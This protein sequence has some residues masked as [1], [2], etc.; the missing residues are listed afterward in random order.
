MLRTPWYIANDDLHRDLNIQPIINVIQNYWTKHT[1]NLLTHSNVEKIPHMELIQ[2]RRQ[3]RT[4]PSEL[5]N[6]Y[7][8]EVH[9]VS[10]K[11]ILR[12]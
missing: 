5:A 1:Q 7:I 2:K 11:N 9:F 6:S 10:K 4:T 3:K 12:I 8:I